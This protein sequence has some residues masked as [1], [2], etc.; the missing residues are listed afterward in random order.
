MIW[1]LE[2]ILRIMES[3]WQFWTRE[4]YRQTWIVELDCGVEDELE[5]NRKEDGPTRWEPV[6][7]KQFRQGIMASQARTEAEELWGKE[8][9][10]YE[11]E[12]VIYEAELQGWQH[13]LMWRVIARERE[14][15]KYL[16]WQ[17]VGWCYSL[18]MYIHGFCLFETITKSNSL[19]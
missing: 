13:H 2:C 3:H 15:S 9:F 18:I 7:Q 19:K 6:G 10:I 16:A 4:Y 12:W 11:S 8:Q 5:A 17:L 1:R 14:K